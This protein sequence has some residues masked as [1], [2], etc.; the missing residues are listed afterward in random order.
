M[1]VSKLHQVG[2]IPDLSA[3][4]IRREL[5]AA[6]RLSWYMPSIS[7]TLKSIRPFMRFRPEKWCNAG[8]GDACKLS[9]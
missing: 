4:G 6:A 2:R 9:L 5:P 1:A 7:T 8:N 3:I